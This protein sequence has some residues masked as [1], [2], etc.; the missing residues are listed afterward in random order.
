MTQGPPRPGMV[1]Q[2]RAPALDKISFEDR[3]SYSAKQGN[4]SRYGKPIDISGK[5]LFTLA[6]LET[7]PQTLAPTHWPHRFAGPLGQL[8]S[9]TGPQSVF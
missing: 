9:T 1:T 7:L 6:R 4:Q 8:Y 3:H 5:Y 2:D